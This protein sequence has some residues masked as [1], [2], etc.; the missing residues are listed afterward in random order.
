MPGGVE[1]RGGQGYP[2]VTVWAWWCEPCRT[3]LPFFQDL[4]RSHNTWN[5]VGVHADSNAA[6]GAAL[7]GDLGVDLPSYQDS[8]GTFA[9]TLG[10]P[11]VIPITLVVR[12]G[13]VVEKFVKPFTSAEELD[14]AVEEAVG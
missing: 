5:V 10:L 13:D 6:N 8:D 11:G 7:L 9:G 2:V 14:K 3:E 1:Q 12:D 4:A